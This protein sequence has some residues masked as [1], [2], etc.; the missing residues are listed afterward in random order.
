[1]NLGFKGLLNIGIMA[2]HGINKME[3]TLEITR[4]MIWQVFQQN[5]N[6]L[7]S[8]ENANLCWGLLSAV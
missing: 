8:F 3:Y 7:L 4:K 1:M 6:A 5:F 2:C